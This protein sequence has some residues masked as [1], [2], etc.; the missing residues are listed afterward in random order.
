MNQTTDRMA[1][2]KTHRATINGTLG[3][4]SYWS[5]CQVNSVLKLDGWRTTKRAQS[6]L[7][8]I[9]SSYGADL[10]PPG[11]QSS[12]RYPILPLASTH[13]LLDDG[14]RGALPIPAWSNYRLF[15]SSAAGCR[16]PIRKG[17]QWI[18][19]WNPWIKKKSF[20]SGKTR[21][22]R[23]HV[24]RENSLLRVAV[25]FFALFFHHV[26]SWTDNV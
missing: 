25:V 1:R 7:P 26:F 23:T 16:P 8:S 9:Q 21:P 20:Q 13:C 15:R 6:T 4:L 12:C 17:I 5:F 14:F 22:H 2:R 18:L 11:A 10:R 19:K 3:V 24:K